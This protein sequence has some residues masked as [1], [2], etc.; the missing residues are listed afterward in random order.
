MDTLVIVDE[1]DKIACCVVDSF[2]SLKAMFVEVRR[3][4]R[5]E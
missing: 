1:S 5:L 2:I 3:N 4:S